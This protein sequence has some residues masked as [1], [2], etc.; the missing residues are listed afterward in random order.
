MAKRKT[1]EEPLRKGNTTRRNSKV[2]IDFET[3]VA[4]GIAAAIMRSPKKPR[5]PGSNPARQGKSKHHILNLIASRPVRGGWN[6][7]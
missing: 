2:A 1:E 5:N 3:L 7:W 4:I 6:S